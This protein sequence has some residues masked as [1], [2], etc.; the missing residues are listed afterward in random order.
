VENEDFRAVLRAVGEIETAQENIQIC[1]NTI[2]V[3]LDFRFSS[4]YRFSIKALPLLF[5]IYF[6]QHYQLAFLL[7]FPFTYFRSYFSLLG[8]TSAV[9]MRIALPP[10]LKRSSE[11]LPR[12][13]L[14][15]I[16]AEKAYVHD[17]RKYVFGRH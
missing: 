4:F 14:T 13:L 5:V 15:Y 10:P 2:K 6:L 1:S 9:L 7:H 8:L 17:H 3:T 16:T 12:V 11:G